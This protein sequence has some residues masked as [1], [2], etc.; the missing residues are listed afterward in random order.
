MEKG[1]ERQREIGGKKTG[2]RRGRKYGWGMVC[3]G[4]RGVELGGFI[5]FLSV[6]LIGCL[7]FGEYL[8]YFTE[9]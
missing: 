5:L 6:V 3:R 8:R 2:G 1:A 4:V 9:C 7:Y